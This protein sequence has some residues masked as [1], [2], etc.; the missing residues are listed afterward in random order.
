MG[1]L[2]CQGQGACSCASTQSQR[3]ACISR[4]VERVTACSERAGI[5]LW[6]VCLMQRGR[7]WAAGLLYAVLLNMK[8]LYVYCAP[9]YFIYILRHWCFPAK[10]GRKGLMAV[11]SDGSLWQGSLEGTGPAH[12]RRKAVGSSRRGGGLKTG[13]VRLF[14][15]GATVAAVCLASLGPFVYLG[16]M[17][18][19]RGCSAD[20]STPPAC[21]SCATGGGS[22]PLVCLT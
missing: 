2:L 22:V 15:M 5:L 10:H 9:L 3:S 17:Q 8:H 12:V 21:T 6:S 19:V 4:Q 13:L 14:I 1:L 18:Q 16:Q 20:H 7:D 11:D